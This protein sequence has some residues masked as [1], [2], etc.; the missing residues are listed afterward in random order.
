M[1][2]REILAGP[3]SIALLAT[4]FCVWSVFGNDINICSSSGCFLYQ[5]FTLNGVSLWWIGATVFS[6]L[7]LLS[8]VGAASLG[9]LVS[10]LALCGDICLLLL[11]ALTAPCVN[12]LIVALFFAASYMTFTYAAEKRFTR[13][14]RQNGK[15]RN[16]VL[17]W[18][19]LALFTINIGA[20]VRTLAGPWPIVEAGDEVTTRL[21]FSPSCSSC[22]EAVAILSGH[23]EVAFYPVAETENDLYKI[24][25]MRESLDSGES[26]IDALN[27]AQE[28]QTPAGVAA[29]SPK[30]LF[31]RFKLLCNKAHVYLA[32]SHVVPFFEYRGMPT[33][34][35]PDRAQRQSP[36]LSQQ[37]RRQ[38]RQNMTTPVNAAPNASDD[39]PVSPLVEGRCAPNAPCP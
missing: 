23:V 25:K 35:K 26:V 32:G 21:F 20:T 30:F 16:S 14:G 38:D 19:W 2:H 17:L 8:L 13:T 4:A 22:R 15:I 9:R 33:M 24:V 28:I 1:N 27:G 10:G 3:L 34:L 7:A 39:V 12:C 18:L 37:G 29:Y 5:D 31:L 6:V 36:S 11:M